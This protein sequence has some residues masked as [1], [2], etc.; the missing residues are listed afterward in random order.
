MLAAEL[1]L[2][3]PIQYSLIWLIIGLTLLLAIVAW[4]GALFW[5]TRRKEAETLADLKSLSPN[6]D[7]PALKAKYLKLIDECYR[8]YQQ[9]Q[10]TRRGLHRGLSMVV[11]Y[12]VYEARHFPA[13]RLTL[14][15][16]KRAP[17]PQLSKLIEQYYSSEFAAI[18]HGDPEAAVAA[19]KELIQQWV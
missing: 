1:K 10:T 12:F 14:A 3:P 15:D 13:P 4:Y 18:E 5:M 9:N 16:L 11:R 17:Y 19:A 2:N 7:L 6:N 8:S